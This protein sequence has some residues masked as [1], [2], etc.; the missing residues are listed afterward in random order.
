M[1]ITMLPI[2]QTAQ[3]L[4][5]STL[6]L[7]KKERCS[8]GSNPMLSGR[9]YIISAG[10]DGSQ[11]NRSI[12]FGLNDDVIEINVFDGEGNKLYEHMGGSIKASNWS[13]VAMTADGNTSRLYIAESD[14]YTVTEVSSSSTSSNQ[15]SRNLDDNAKFGDGEFSEGSYGGGNSITF[16]DSEKW[17]ESKLQDFIGNTKK[18][19]L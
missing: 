4:A 3:H 15:G 17:S 7:N 8:L 10:Y 11:A 12:S 2:E 16:K 1:E 5:G 14:T 19:Y 6:Y 9:Q 18:L 13:V